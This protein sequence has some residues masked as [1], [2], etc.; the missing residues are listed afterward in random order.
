MQSKILK[1]QPK[2]LIPAKLQTPVN[3]KVK[4]G[5][6]LQN[7]YFATAPIYCES[8]A[9]TVNNVCIPI[10]DSDLQVSFTYTPV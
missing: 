9:S 7:S 5:G 4:K 6:L 2:M 1:T 8:S 3:S 10:S